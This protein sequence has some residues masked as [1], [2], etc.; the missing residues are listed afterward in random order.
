M[1]VIQAIIMPMIFCKLRI[2]LD[3]IFDSVLHISMGPWKYNIIRT[4]EVVT[5]LKN[6]FVEVNVNTEFIY[7]EFFEG[8]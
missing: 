6:Y 5:L 1:F 8:L 4:I 3:F 7:G 2:Y